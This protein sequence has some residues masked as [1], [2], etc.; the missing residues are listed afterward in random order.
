MVEYQEKLDN[1]K[2][3]YT[4]P[5]DQVKLI[6]TE[7]NLRKAIINSELFDHDIINT[8]VKN[9]KEDIKAID[10]LLANDRTL[11]EPGN[12]YERLLLF[13]KKRW[14]ID[15]IINRFSKEENNKIVETIQKSINVIE[16]RAK[17]YSVLN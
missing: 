10:L 13:D 15:H 14:I 4:K 8:I 7:K 5:K 3:I 16:K 17:Q 6:A 2:K 12:E 1:L 11:S 9:A